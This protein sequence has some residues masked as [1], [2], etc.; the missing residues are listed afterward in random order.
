[1]KISCFINKDT[2]RHYKQILF[3]KEQDKSGIMRAA[4]DFYWAYIFDE[5]LN[6]ELQDIVSKTKMKILEEENNYVNDGE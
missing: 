5:E 3:L 1:M 6:D 2:E 4:I